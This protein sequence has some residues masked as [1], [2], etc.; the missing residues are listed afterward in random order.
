MANEAVAISVPGGEKG[1][2]YRFTVSDGI[3]I[4]KGDILMM[5][6][7][8]T[9][10]KPVVTDVRVPWAGI[11]AFEKEASGAA[12]STGD[13]TMGCIREGIYDLYVA[14]A[15]SI[16]SQLVISGSSTGS[17]GNTLKSDDFA[18][19]AAVVGYAMEVTTANDT[20]NV[21]LAG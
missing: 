18:S 6:G 1:K 13:T 14:G 2:P 17:M 19:G 11:A 15:C 5:S 3:G 7:A 16:G 21:L 20:I 12:L 4:Q 9:A 10:A 8:L